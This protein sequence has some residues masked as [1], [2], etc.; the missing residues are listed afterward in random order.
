M[1]LQQLN[2]SGQSIRSFFIT[3]IA[4]LLITA[5]MWF[6]IVQYNSV[7]DWKRKEDE[8]RHP[9]SSRKRRPKRSVI[10]RVA[11]LFG[12]LDEDDFQSLDFD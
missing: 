5:L 3:A 4:A 7:S 11:L 6:C 12:I 2:Q 9:L 8:E 1:N 10:L